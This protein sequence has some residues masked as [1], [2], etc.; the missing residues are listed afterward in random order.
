MRSLYP[1]DISR[2]RFEIILPDLESCR[3]KTEPR[4][5]DLYDVF[6]GVSEK[7]LSVENATK[8]VSKMVQ[9]L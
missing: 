3:K 6:C 7:R 8:R 9:L 5:L 2:E 4:K 1:G